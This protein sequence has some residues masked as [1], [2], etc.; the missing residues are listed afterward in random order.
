MTSHPLRRA[1]PLATSRNATPLRAQPSPGG[2]TADALAGASGDA[3]LR[4]VVPA[5][6]AGIDALLELLPDDD[7][8]AWETPDGD[9]FAGAGRLRLPALR[10]QPLDQP[11]H[12]HTLIEMRLDLLHIG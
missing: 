11:L 1:I 9:R 7:A 5:P 12:L 2:F 8:F 3:L 6:D 4:I 10:L